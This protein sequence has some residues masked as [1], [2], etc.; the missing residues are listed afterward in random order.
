MIIHA[1]S[2]LKRLRGNDLVLSKSILIKLAVDL[3]SFVLKNVEPD[4]SQPEE[5]ADS[6]AI[7]VRRAW[8]CIGILARLHAI[9]TATDDNIAPHDFDDIGSAEDCATI[10]PEVTSFLA[11][12]SNVLS[13]L[14]SNILSLSSQ[15]HLTLFR[16]RSRKMIEQH[17]KF[18]ISSTPRSRETTLIAQELGLFVSI[19]LARHTFINHPADILTP[20]L[21]LAEILCATITA[22]EE[23]P[24]YNPYE[25]H[26]FA[27]TTMTLLEFTDAM[28]TDLS[29]PALDALPKIQRVLEQIAEL[30]NIEK[31]AG[32]TDSEEQGHDLPSMHWATGLLRMINLKLRPTKSSNG[33]S[34]EDEVG[35]QSDPKIPTNGEVNTRNGQGVSL[36]AARHLSPQRA[37]QI[38]GHDGQADKIVDAK[39]GTVQLVDFRLLLQH[40]YLNVVAERCGF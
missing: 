34:G 3:G 20:A 23:K 39:T 37:A 18:I 21:E 31:Q 17:L 27:L 24:Q 36:L 2:D 12:S 11:R 33:T 5:P 30:A 16:F 38:S 8:N 40:G 7:L 26:L 10:L 13:I 29:N 14:S 35:E 9:S 15:P 1:D 6:N 25:N 19:L 22:T 32:S 28:D 4:V